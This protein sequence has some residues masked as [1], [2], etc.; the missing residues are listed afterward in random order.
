MRLCITGAT[1]F[2]G[3]ALLDALSEAGDIERLT[4]LTLPG[5]PGL[6]RVR[7]KKLPPLTIVEGDITDPLR[8]REALKGSTHVIHL[9]GL[10][11][12]W[13]RD[14]ER[15]TRIN[16]DGVAC[17]V[18]ACLEEG[19]QRL[20]HVSSV[21]AVG[22]FKDGRLADEETEFNWPDSFCYMTTKRAGREVVEE[23][24]RERG[25]PA[26]ILNPASLMGPGDP[27][28]R[29]AHNQLYSNISRGPFLGC[30]AGGLAVTDVRD[31]AAVAVKALRVGAVGR[32]YLVVGS[33]VTYVQVVRAI[34]DWFGGKVYPFR[35]PSFLLTA[36][37][38]IMEAASLL[39]GR[40]PLLTA[41]Y[42]KLS[43]WQGY[44][45]NRRS[46]EAFGHEYIPFPRTIADGCAFW[47]RTFGARREAGGREGA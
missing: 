16:R 23:A 26:V 12:Y 34:G 3:N 17:V 13:R 25:L 30:F 36:A 1:G 15:L 9:A 20:V 29:S 22:F 2:A 41:S 4:L 8:V 35:I 46:V 19:V 43:G 32:R 14:R 6:P 31:L 33:N 38:G 44:Y 27:D 11:S 18:D 40:K 47:A 5:D 24:V 21:G 10:I 45:S 28:P 42:G 37:G 7:A 39:T